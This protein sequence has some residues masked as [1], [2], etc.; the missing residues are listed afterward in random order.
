MILLGEVPV[1]PVRDGYLCFAKFLRVSCLRIQRGCEGEKVSRYTTRKRA[2]KSHRLSETPVAWRNTSDTFT[3]RGLGY[4]C[5]SCGLVKCFELKESDGE[6]RRSCLCRQPARLQPCARLLVLVSLYAACYAGKIVIF[7]VG[8][9]KRLSGVH[10][11]K[12][13]RNVWGETPCS[14]AGPH[15][16]GWRSPGRDHLCEWGAVAKG[17]SA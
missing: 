2:L 15:P 1:S 3:P 10:R 16:R 4:N 14:R 6:L 9:R 5:T 11:A 7:E 17:A 8:S 13:C 12:K